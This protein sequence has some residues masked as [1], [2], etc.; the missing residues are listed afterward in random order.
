[1]IAQ[2]K[3]LSRMPPRASIPTLLRTGL[4]YTVAMTRT[5]TRWLLTALLV[6][7]SP[8]WAGEIAG[9]AQVVSGDTIVINDTHI[10]L[11]G[12]D[13]PEIDQTCTTRKG[14]AMRCGELARQALDAWMR[15]AQVQCRGDGEPSADAPWAAVCTI[16]WLDINEEIVTEGWAL[17]LSTESDAYV[18]AETFAKAR[19]EGIWR[20]EFVPPWEWKRP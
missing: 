13:A 10:R 4:V 17:A 1:M 16:G 7:S 8:A 11:Y 2:A 15:G 3:G 20:T 18:R 12:I 9:R 6:A 19:K 5:M 14:E